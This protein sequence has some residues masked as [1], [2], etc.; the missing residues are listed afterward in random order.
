MWS[1]GKDSTATVLLFHQHEKELINEGDTVV[2]NFV[3]IMFDIKE[4]VSGHNP[5]IV[6]FIYEKK[7]V[8]ESWGYEVNILRA[9]TDF[10]TRFGE[11]LKNCPDPARNG[12][13]RGFPLAGGMCW[14]KRDLKLKPL[15]AYKKTLAGK[16]YVE[17]VGIAAD[18]IE[19]Y[20][21]LKRTNPHAVSL[22]VDYDYTES[23]AKALC[24]KYEMLSPQYA[25]NDGKQKRDGC[26]FCPYAKLCEHNS[27]RKVNPTA[28]EKYVPLESDAH[29]GYPKWNMYAKETL[30]DREEMLK[31]G[32]EQLTMFGMLPNVV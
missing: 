26:W 13:K 22:L 12:L 8:F 15:N 27:I 4:N 10:L 3:E 18:E 21:S 14:V 9:E 11:P 6:K 29:L 17:Y 31:N 5:D 1:G 24:L 28:W 25:L 19:R 32:G 23:D 7:A 16:E 2:I 20:K 30:H